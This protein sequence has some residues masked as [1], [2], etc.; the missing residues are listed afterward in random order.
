MALGIPTGT[1]KFPSTY[2]SVLRERLLRNFDFYN[3][4][5]VVDLWLH[6]LDG[7]HLQISNIGYFKTGQIL[8]LG[9]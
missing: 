5:W 3:F 6:A 1:S 4:L 2:H 9:Y 8:N 7:L